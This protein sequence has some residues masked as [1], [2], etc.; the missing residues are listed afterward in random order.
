MLTTASSARVPYFTLCLLLSWLSLLCRC[1]LAHTCSVSVS[2]TSV[3]RM[4]PASDVGHACQVLAQHHGSCCGRAACRKPHT[5]PA[6][7]GSS[8]VGDAGVC[9]RNSTVQFSNWGQGPAST[10]ASDPQAHEGA[11]RAY[12]RTPGQV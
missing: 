6:N 11:Q 4:E 8:H 10:L 3:P 7:A 1:L 12:L 9:S 2:H 5:R